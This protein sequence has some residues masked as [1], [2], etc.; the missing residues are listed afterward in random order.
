L[1]FIRALDRSVTAIKIFLKKFKSL[2]KFKHN[3]RL[4]K[5]L[6][7]IFYQTFLIFCSL[8]NE[9]LCLNNIIKW[10]IEW[11]NL[12]RFL[13]EE[14]L[15]ITTIVYAL[16]LIFIGLFGVLLGFLLGLYRT[17][18]QIEHI[19]LFFLLLLLNILSHK[20]F[21]D[22][23]LADL[24]DSSLATNIAHPFYKFSFK[25][26]PQIE[27]RPFKLILKETQQR[28][29]IPLPILPILDDPSVNI[30]I[31]FIWDESINYKFE[32]FEFY[33]NLNE[34]VKY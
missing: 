20:E 8:V 33:Q 13:M 17:K 26:L 11:R 3:F 7:G 1:L 4:L 9:I 21:D 6:L 19:S 23:L 31:D 22:I 28:T 14:S 24:T 34:K 10:L 32:L 27:S 30:E 25:T 15:F 5:N 16:Y 2:L 18:D 29:Q 12:I